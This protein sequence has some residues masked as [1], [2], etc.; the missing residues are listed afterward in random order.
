MMGIWEFCIILIF[1]NQTVLKMKFILKSYE[2]WLMYLMW[3]WEMTWCDHVC[4]L[5]R[6]FWLAGS[7]PLEQ[8]G[9]KW[10][11]TKWDQ[12]ETDYLE[13]SIARES[14]TI[15][16]VLTQRLEVEWE[17]FI[18][19]KREGFRHTSNWRLLSWGKM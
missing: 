4:I 1:K 3:G 18:V 8:H 5:R 12:A 16:C 10:R 2:K 15:I 6:L 19:D 14:A 7:R 13:L 9:N 11:P 17:K